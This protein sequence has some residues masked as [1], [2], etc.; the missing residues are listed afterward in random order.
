MI[1]WLAAALML[2]LI[3]SAALAQDDAE[4]EPGEPVIHEVTYGDTLFRIALRYG[5]T[6]D[7]IAEANDIVYTWNIQ[8]GEKLVIPGLTVP[9]DSAEVENPLVAAAPVQHVI[10]PGETLGA[11][12][13]RYGVTA[14]L[15]LRANNIANPNLIYYGQV[16]NIWTPQTVDS[17]VDPD[18]A[19]VAEPSTD[20]ASPDDVATDTTAPDV[21]EL[22]D[23]GDIPFT[24]VVRNGETLG[25]IANFY[26]LSLSE[27]MDANAIGNAN[28]VYAGSI[29]TIPGRSGRSTISTTNPAELAEFDARPTINEGKQIVVD[30]SDQRVYAFDNGTMVFSALVST[31]LPATP[32][33]LGDYAVYIRL[34]S[35]RMTGPGYDLP[36]VQWVQYFYEGYGL[37]G[38]YWHNNFGQPMS[39]GCV[40]LTN[41][42]AL[43]LFQWAS[44]GTPVHVRA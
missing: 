29:L 41:A 23:V 34:E 14:D 26:G 30:L 10:R 22:P 36:G 33:V 8:I 35:Q 13:S 39:H 43:W 32:T 19:A 5:V 1:R 28:L 6:V 12:A 27:L 18:T 2:L 24:H 15:I 21:G 16:L 31:G 17:T 11:I 37:H 9:D 42:D 25:R 40:N 7:E 4:A 38:T 44:I 3:G 20:A